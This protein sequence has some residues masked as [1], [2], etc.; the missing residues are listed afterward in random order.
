MTSG[1]W[2]FGAG[3]VFGAFGAFEAFGAVAFKAFEAFGP[4]G[5]SGRS[6]HSG[7]SGLLGLQSFLHLVNHVAR[8]DANCDV[9]E[10]PEN[11]Q[12]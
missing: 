3:R 4:S 11:Q 10:I 5:S 2:A 12:R 8:N 6:G 7:P 1:R 9:L